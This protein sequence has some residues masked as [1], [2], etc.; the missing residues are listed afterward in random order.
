[1]WVTS[2]ASIA[3]RVPPLHLPTEPFHVG[4]TQIVFAPQVADLGQVDSC[5]FRRESDYWLLKLRKVR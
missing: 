3:T 5:L 2:T 4:K 1:M